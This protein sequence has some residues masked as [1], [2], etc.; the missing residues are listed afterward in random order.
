VLARNPKEQTKLYTEIE[1]QFD[2]KS[3]VNKQKLENEI[4]YK[5]L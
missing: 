2:I 4:D 1:N 5:M 3:K